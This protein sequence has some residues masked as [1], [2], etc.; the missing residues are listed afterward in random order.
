MPKYKV[1]L[2]VEHEVVAD[3]IEAAVASA[4][5]NADFTQ[6]KEEAIRVPMLNDR[7]LVMD[8]HGANV[9]GM[10][11]VGETVKCY[12]AYDPDSG[13]V[14]SKANPTEP[15]EESKLPPG[16]RLETIDAFKIFLDD[17]TTKYSCQ[18]FWELEE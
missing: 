12:V 14:V 2:F 3:T 6:V 15:I 7:L 16:F 1:C 17:G 5:E 10:G 18:V 4:K 13:G 8:N 9:I 11:T